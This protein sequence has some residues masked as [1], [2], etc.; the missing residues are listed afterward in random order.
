MNLK[1]TCYDIMDAIP[2]LWH[3]VEI[4]TQEMLYRQ[5]RSYALEL[6]RGEIDGNEFL[7]QF[8]RT[9]TNQLTKAW[10]EGALESDVFPQDM[11]DEDM[12]ELSRL[13]ADEMEYVYGLGDDIIIL[14]RTG[15]LE[16]FRTQIGSRLDIWANR[17][18]EVAN[19]AK[20]WFG[21]KTKYVWHL[22]T[23]EEHCTT[24]SALNGIVAWAEEWT[25]AKVVPGEANS[26]YLEC[27]GWRCDCRLD[28]VGRDVRRTRNALAKILEV[29]GQ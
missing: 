28:S 9:I 18:N 21:G 26:Q 4:K 20:V 7:T 24:C 27:H 23:T 15:T 11:T 22:G 3:M 14:A 29:T 5:L 12:T 10:Y 17:Y 6:F 1:Q 19:R 2:V 13:I 8:E 16:N 25:R